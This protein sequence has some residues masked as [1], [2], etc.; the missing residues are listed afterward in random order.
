MGNSA[1]SC[2]PPVLLIAKL[3]S[4]VHSSLTGILWY[5]IQNK[6]KI[7]CDH[8]SFFSTIN[9]SCLLSSPGDKN[10]KS[11]KDLVPKDYEINLMQ[12]PVHSPI[13][14]TTTWI[15]DFQNENKRTQFR[16]FLLAS[17]FRNADNLEGGRNDFIH[18]LPHASL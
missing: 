2:D 9:I 17:L 12:C 7:S 4:Q 16:E 5:E 1:L 3:L 11:N 6:Q 8:M 15:K 10:F 13:Q 18:N 14:R